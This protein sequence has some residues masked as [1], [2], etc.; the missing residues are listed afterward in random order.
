[1]GANTS[2][3]KGIRILCILGIGTCLC[4][5][6]ARYAF[7]YLNVSEEIHP[8]ISQMLETLDIHECTLIQLSDYD[9][10]RVSI[11]TP[12][13]TE[14]EY[15]GYIRSQREEED[16][17]LTDDELRHQLLEEKKIASLMQARA[18][19]MD[20]L[21]SRCHFSLKEENV[22]AYA[23]TIVHNYETEAALYDMSLIQ[24]SQ[25]ILGYTKEQFYQKCYE[26]GEEAIK[27]F[28]VIGAVAEKEFPDLAQKTDD[29]N[30][31]LQYQEIENAVYS[32]F[33]ETDND[34]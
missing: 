32:Y 13:I 2:H 14:D 31:Y 8:V 23:K 15:A 24:Y 1:M 9:D 26:E 34:F 28:L 25:E 12:I 7:T 6:L 16:T 11:E 27:S 19:V 10:I 29:K 18:K 22:A 5:I 4:L 3:K 17:D 30:I 33:I 20:A 21:L